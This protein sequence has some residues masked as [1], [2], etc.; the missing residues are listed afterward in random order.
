MPTQEESNSIYRTDK[1]VVFVLL[2]I[3]S[4][5]L[6]YIQ[7]SFIENETATF[8]FL[9]DRPQGAILRTL[10]TLKY[11]AIPIVYLWK[12]TVIA[13]VVWVGCFT[14]G[15]RITYSQCWGIVLIAEFVFLL[16]SIAKIIYFLFIH[17]D[18]TLYEVQAFYPLSALSFFEYESLDPRYIYPLKSF[19]V[20]EAGYLALLAS[21][22]HFYT[23]REKKAS[24][25]IVLGTYV[26]L[27][28]LWLIFYMLVYH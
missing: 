23:H 7:I 12:F 9:A 4:M 1:K 13:F 15:F 14:F 18:P 3:L 22:I 10:N 21:G 2:C 20:F 5:L 16:A 26:P 17:T 25:M 8:E 28:L 11:F 24:W 6:L 27:F 19:S